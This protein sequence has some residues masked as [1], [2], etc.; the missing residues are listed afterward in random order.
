MDICDA[1]N[2]IWTDGLDDSLKVS[3]TN[4]VMICEFF[5]Q[6]SLDSLG[7]FSIYGHVPFDGK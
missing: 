7:F 1:C 2:I 6:K 3:T 4:V 5:N